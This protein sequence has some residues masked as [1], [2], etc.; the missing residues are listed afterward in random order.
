MIAEEHVPVVCTKQPSHTV[1]L[2]EDRRIRCTK[3]A[4]VATR[5]LILTL[6]TLHVF[7]LLTRIT[8][9]TCQSIVFCLI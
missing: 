3:C 2:V 8:D 5:A 4:P 6:F 7:I 9:I 1:Q